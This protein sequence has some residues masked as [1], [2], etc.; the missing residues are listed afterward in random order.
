MKDLVKK[1]APILK[2]SK[3]ENFFPMS[4]DAYLKYCALYKD[5]SHIAGPPLT[6]AALEHVAQDKYLVYADRLD[7][8]INVEEALC[9]ALID[10]QKYIVECGFTGMGLTLDRV[11]VEAAWDAVNCRAW[12]DRSK[13]IDALLY[14]VTLIVNYTGGP[15]AWEFIRN[16]LGPCM[17]S[18]RVFDQA[19]ENYRAEKKTIK[20]TCYYYEMDDPPFHV[21]EYWYFYAFNDGINWHE[22]DWESVVLYFCNDKPCYAV[23]AGHD[24]HSGPIKIKAESPLVCVARG[25]HASYPPTMFDSVN[26]AGNCDLYEECNQTLEGWDY[27]PL[28]NLAWPHFG[29]S[30]GSLRQKGIEELTRKFGGPPKGPMQHKEQ[31]SFPVAWAKKYGGKMSI[32]ECTTG[33]KKP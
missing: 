32:D 15:H 24:H 13:V 20:P 10:L 22:A 26:I 25:S 2:F 28:S 14:F 1:Y 27:Q 30:W 4:I 6:P 8:A 31:W 17:L 19:L 7:E 21:I 23:Y 9:Q 29:G 12:G 11:A 3:G 5:S 16:T 18:V 33:I